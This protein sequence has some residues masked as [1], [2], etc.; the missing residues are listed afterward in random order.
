MHSQGWHNLQTH[1]GRKR[2]GDEGRERAPR[3]PKP[4]DPANRAGEDVRREDALGLV[5]GHGIHGP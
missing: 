2:A 3:L 1:A 5:D 4:G